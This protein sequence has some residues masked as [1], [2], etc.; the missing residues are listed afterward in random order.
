M[1]ASGICDRQNQLV[2][3]HSRVFQPPKVFR[4]KG[5]LVQCKGVLTIGAYSSII[6]KNSRRFLSFLAATGAG[7]GIRSPAPAR[8]SCCGAFVAFSISTSTSGSVFS[9]VF[10][11]LIPGWD[12]SDGLVIVALGVLEEVGVGIVTVGG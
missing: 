8:G 12:G 3:D 2:T 10:S 5:I 11:D 9:G 6:P 7:A 4:W 1:T